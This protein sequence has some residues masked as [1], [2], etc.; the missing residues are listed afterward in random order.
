MGKEEK[1]PVQ[2]DNNRGGRL[3]GNGGRQT[4]PARQDLEAVYNQEVNFYRE[5]SLTGG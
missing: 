5:K 2:I 4:L 3:S 1:K